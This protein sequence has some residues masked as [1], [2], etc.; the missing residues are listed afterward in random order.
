MNPVALELL[1]FPLIQGR[2]AIHLQHNQDENCKGR[3]VRRKNNSHIPALPPLSITSY[4]TPKPT[5]RN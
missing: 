4:L 2:H 3:L 5:R 1:Y